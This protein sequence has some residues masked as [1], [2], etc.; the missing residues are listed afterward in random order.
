MAAA[1][2]N[3]QSATRFSLSQASFA[4]I[5]QLAYA[6]F[7]LNLK[8]SKK[9]LVH[10]RLTRRL[11]KLGMSSFE[12]YCD[13]LRS[14]DG[15]TERM[16][17][18]SA[19]TTNVTQFFR[20][21]HHFKLLEEEI[22]PKAKRS[23]GNGVRYRIWSAGCSAGQEPYSI[24][25]SVLKAMPDAAKFDL[26]ILATDVDPNILATGQQ[27]CYSADE[28]G[29]IPEKYRQLL[30]GET[31]PKGFEIP[32]QTKDL[33]TFAELN[34][35]KDWPMPGKFD[36]IFC[37]NVAIYFDKPT[38]SRIWAGFHEKLNPGGY[39]FIG[40]SERLSADITRHFRSV[41]VTAFQKDGAGKVQNE[42][43]RKD[44]L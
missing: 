34:L 27:G 26:K 17:L 16:H 2:Q 24:A 8:E 7:G 12:Q 20:E 31:G 35:V 10:S 19:L 4:Y 42:P 14:R 25:A 5:A 43:G 28:Q 6:D 39:L 40:H 41:G 33:I 18:L 3:L 30:C 38:Q 9:D 22:L 21:A 15:Q 37:R 11:R 1:T 36:V 13:F 32:Q 23:I 29:S 44:E